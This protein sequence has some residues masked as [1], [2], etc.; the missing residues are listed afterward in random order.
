MLLAVARASPRILLCAVHTMFMGGSPC[1]YFAVPFPSTN[2]PF[3]VTVAMQRYNALSST[4]RRIPYTV[5]RG[6]SDWV[7]T[8]LNNRGSGMWAAAP[9][10][11]D[12]TEGYK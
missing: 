12:L 8:P 11:E 4:R 3:A 5:V 10:V 2:I 6:M 9:A 1:A 7:H